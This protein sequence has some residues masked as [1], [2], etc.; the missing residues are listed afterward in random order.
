VPTEFDDVISIGVEVV[1]DPQGY[2]MEWYRAENIVRVGLP[3]HLC[4]TINRGHN[5]VLYADGMRRK[6]ICKVSW[7]ARF[8]V[9]ISTLLSM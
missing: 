7:R 9:Q 1:D 4:R 2:F 8:P 3:T 5:T 6:S